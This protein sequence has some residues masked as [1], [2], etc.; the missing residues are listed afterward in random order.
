MSSLDRLPPAAP[1]IASSPSPNSPFWVPALALERPK[2]RA[3]WNAKSTYLISSEH[4]EGLDKLDV[5]G[6]G[7][8]A[9]FF[10]AT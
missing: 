9:E 6:M 5:L 2:P 1:P 3:S 7:D 4:V 10:F 8:R